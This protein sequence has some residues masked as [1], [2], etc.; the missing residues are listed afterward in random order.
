MNEFILAWVLVVSPSTSQNSPII[1]LPVVDLESCQR[2]Q[3]AMQAAAPRSTRCV[4]VKLPVITVP[5]V[6]SKEGG[7]GAKGRS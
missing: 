1:S 7:T 3:E 2:L 4:Q 6:E 5:K